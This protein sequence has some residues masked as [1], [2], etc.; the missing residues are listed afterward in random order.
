M[1]LGGEA[2]GGF[3][4]KARGGIRGKA[5]GGSR[6][7]ARRGIRRKAAPE[8]LQQ[9]RCNGEAEA[10]EG[11]RMKRRRRRGAGEGK[12]ENCSKRFGNNR[13]SIVISKVK[14]SVSRALNS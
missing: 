12:S 2:G 13:R 8:D 4:G 14:R 3:R 11:R 10:D 9:R 1:A 6:G 7:K 5:R